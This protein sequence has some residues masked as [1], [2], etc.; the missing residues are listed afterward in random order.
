[1]NHSIKFDSE[2][3]SIIEAG[4]WHRVVSFPTVV[5]IYHVVRTNYFILPIP[6]KCLLFM[7]RFCVKSFQQHKRY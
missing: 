5:S 6:S 2:H 3:Y 1:M 7:S 4:E